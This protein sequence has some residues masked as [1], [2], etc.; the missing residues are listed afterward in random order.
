MEILI[1]TMCYLGFAC[2][3]LQKRAAQIQSGKHDP[4]LITDKEHGFKFSNRLFLFLFWWTMPI[5]YLFI[6]PDFKD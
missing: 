6:D 5:V 2:H 3:F 4:Y 1:F